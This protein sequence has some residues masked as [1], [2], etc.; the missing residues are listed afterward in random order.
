MWST[1]MSAE[2]YLAM[3]IATP[4]IKSLEGPEAV[5]HPT[6]K[7]IALIHRNPTSMHATLFSYLS[8]DSRHL[9]DPIGAAEDSAVEDRGWSEAFR[10]QVSASAIDHL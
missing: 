2:S 4:L 9:L 3:F 8:R 5:T 1:S 6:T 10:R 7:L